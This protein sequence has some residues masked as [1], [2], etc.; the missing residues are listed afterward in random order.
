M[1]WMTR[2]QSLAGAG[3]LSPCHHV[4]TGSEAHPAH[5]PMGTRGYFP[6]EGKA[7]RE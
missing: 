4:Q 7:V 6:R 2:I 3:I 5:Y 1:S